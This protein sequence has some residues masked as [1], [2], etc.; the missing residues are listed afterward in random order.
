MSHAINPTGPW[1][2]PLNWDVETSLDGELRIRFPDYVR[3]GEKS[4]AEFPQ[5]S[6]LPIEIQ[7]RMISFCD[8]PSLFQLM[9]VS[10]AIRKEAKRYFWSNPVAWFRV[11]GIF[12]DAAELLG[13]TMD[14]V[15]FLAHIQQIEITV[16]DVLWYNELEDLTRGDGSLID[17]AATY[18]VREK[19]GNL[20]RTLRVC[21]AQFDRPGQWTMHALNSDHDKD[22]VPPEPFRPAFARHKRT[23]DLL[24]RF[25]TSRYQ[26]VESW[27]EEGS[28]KR[29]EA[30]KAF[31][32]Q[33]DHDPLYSLG[34]PAQYTKTWDELKKV[35]RERGGTRFG[36]PMAPTF[37]DFWD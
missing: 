24:V 35:I 22:A 16:E 23:M 5:F 1:A 34:K 32:D 9:H 33:L 14:D 30:E 19:L 12:L 36:I 6:K 31:L 3:S 29:H 17:P 26:I 13:R 18:P 8:T 28:A 4:Q 37:W 10:S 2:T 11:W 20:W 27:G 7:Y 25:E 15:G 21:G